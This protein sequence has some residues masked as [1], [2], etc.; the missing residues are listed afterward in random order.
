[1]SDMRDKKRDNKGMDSFGK[2]SYNDASGYVFGTGPVFVPENMPSDIFR[3]ISPLGSDRKGPFRLLTATRY[4]KR[5]LLKC[6]SADYSRDPVYSM[7]QAKEFEIG[8]TLDHPSIRRTLGFEEVAGFGRAVILEYIDGEPLDRALKD[9]RITKD[10]ARSVV[11]QLASALEYIHTR[12]IYHRDIKPSNILL[13]YSGRQ[14]KLIDF[15]LS[16]SGSYVILKNPA[17]TKRYLAPEQMNADA[18]P[19]SRADI[20]SFGVV[21]GEIAER[22][23]DKELGRIAKV[24]ADPDPFKRP[25]SLSQIRLPEQMDLSRRVAGNIMDSKLLTIILG[26]VATVMV[27]LIAWL[28]WFKPVA[29]VADDGRKPPSTDIQ[30]MDMS[31]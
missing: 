27:L 12:Q 8:I 23:G 15:S 19:S 18:K 2:D 16:D 25:E 6:L 26:V 20:Y 29:D 28:I 31:D 1:M 4:G 14:V 13:T 30:I 5:Y 3:N 21:V 10:N 17:G 9:G 24:C 11:S 7:I 22:V